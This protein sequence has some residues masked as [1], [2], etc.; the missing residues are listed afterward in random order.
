MGTQILGNLVDVHSKNTY[1]VKVIIE[2][3]IIASITPIEDEQDTFIIPG[4]VDAHI[5]IESSLLTPGYFADIAISHGTI[6]TVSDPHEIANVCGLDG[7]E[8]MIQ[9]G[10]SSDLRFFGRLHRAYQP[11]ASKRQELILGPLK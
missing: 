3:G 9:D 2:N 1:P 6:A 4:F 10:Q 11:R 7:I 8:F 5:H